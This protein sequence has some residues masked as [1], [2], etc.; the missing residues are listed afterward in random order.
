[1][2]A[3]LSRLSIRQKLAALLMLTS[4]I[5]LVV[6]SIAYLTWDYFRFRADMR[7][8]LATQAEL[9]LDNT[10]AALTF[11]D[12]RAAR[13]ALEMLSI[14][15]H[16]RL[17]CLYSGTGTL[18][19]E[20][21]FDEPS[22]EEPCPAAVAP[23]ARFTSNR[24]EVIEQLTRGRSTGG[25]VLLLSDLDAS[26]S[27]LETQG[28]AVF[29]ILIG[30]L[31]LSFLLSFSL[32]RVVA[33]PIAALAGTA[34]EIAD[35]GDY[36]LRAKPASKDEIGLLVETFNRMLDEIE[37]SQRERAGL[38]EREQEA[39]RLKDEF[40]ATLSHELRTPLNAIVGWV[41]LLRTGH[42]PEEERRHAIDRI[43]RNAHA[44]AKLVQDL[45][46]VSR[47]T[48]GKLHLDVRE[49]DLAAV[50]NNAIDAC[51]PAADAR[52][53]SIVT[54]F[55]GAFPT[56]GDPDR[57][58]QVV[59]NLLSNAVRFT[60][61]N[62]RVTVS[63]ARTDG[64][65]T[66]RVRDTGAGIEAPF[67]PFVFEPF[68]QADA[69]STRAHGGLGIGLTIVRRLTEMHGG[70]VAVDSDGPG[71]GATFT[72][73]LP[74]RATRGADAL[75][76]EPARMATLAGANVLVVDDDP[77]TLELLG[78]TL[79]MAGARP[80]PAAS[81]A[82]ALHVIDGHVV[83]AVVSDIAMPGQDGYTLISLLKD[84]MGPAMPTAT[85]AL[86]AYAGA[87]DRRRA[88]ESGFR[89]HLAKPV[90]PNVL[91]QTLE[92]LLADAYTPPEL[93]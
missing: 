2:T 14:N 3:V 54:Q 82:E 33:R 91:V 46:D 21:R 84:R 62:G 4:S 87:T 74:V 61:A 6:A 19:T 56:K 7:T 70:T 36:S 42:L 23:G 1:M 63:I 59:W 10:A 66:L 47:I 22:R 80:L 93:R 71:L 73:T 75:A 49:M 79:K 16:V 68:R 28:A 8:D 13:E 20:V 52:Q 53:V 58:Q 31:A 65:D 78:A 69:A 86:T 17:A 85:L 72:V 77:D 12:P 32:Q 43:D 38:L 27:R 39:N 57:L 51:R 50:A 5:V 67:V 37:S 81:V 35:R 55:S 9:V 45:L 64:F 25:R 11:N 30:G 18:F 83:D 60:P 76:S 29:A 44:Q 26:V 48:T 90:N 41:H 15:P 89:E 34:R 40:L 24:L 88:L 92:D